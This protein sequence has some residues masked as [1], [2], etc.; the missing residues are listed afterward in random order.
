MD[1]RYAQ[2]LKSLNENNR[3]HSNKDDRILIIDGLN[4]FIRSFVVVPTVNENG[5]H[6]GGITGFLMSIGYAIRNIKPTRVV[7]CFDGKGGSQRRRKLFPDYKANRRVK[8][9]MTRINEFNSVDDERIA[10][11][12]QLQRL[13]EYLQTLP[14]TVMATENIEADDAMAY[15]SQQIYPKSQCILMSTDKDFLQLVDDRVQVWSPTK[16]KFY[17]KDTLK[18]EFEIESKN[19]LMYRVLTGDSSDN[20]PGIKGAGT[21]TLMRRLPILF[22]DK[23]LS[24]EKLFDYIDNSDDDTK[25]MENISN[26]R[27]QLELNYQ[28]MQLK[29][30]D[31]SGRAKESINNICK[32]TMQKLNKP[33]FLQMLL[34]DTINMN[35]K[36]PQLWLKDTFTILNSFALRSGDNK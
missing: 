5:T 27:E 33:K 11:G 4:T 1:K 15:I 6:V 7:I 8:H 29:E 30:V 20:I 12:Q 26:N 34:E 16:K 22:E 13:A 25:L 10:M 36:N 35:I 18:E 23:E 9:R 31:I 19:F 14:I 3:L 2:M 32:A 24:L 28:L 17:F 21:K